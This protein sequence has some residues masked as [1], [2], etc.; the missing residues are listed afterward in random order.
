MNKRRL[1]AGIAA[2]ALC[3]QI[4]YAARGEV[5][6]RNTEENGRIARTVWEDENGQPAAGPEGYASVSYTYGTDRNT[7]EMYFDAEGQPYL[8]EGGYCGRRIQKDGKG[9]VIL[10]EY[11]DR[12]GKRVL[13]RKGYGM[14][15]V[16]YFQFGAV[17]NV[18]YYGLKK[19]VT[20]PSLGYASIVYEYSNKTMVGKTFRDE[21]GNDVDCADGYASIRQKVDKQYRVLNTRYTHADGSL[22]AGPDGWARCVRERD[23]KGRITSIR[24]YDENEQL[25]DRGTGYAWEEYT[26]DGDDI[27]KVTRY[28]ADGNPVADKAGVVTFVREEKDGRVLRERFLD[29]DGNRVTNS[30]AVAEIVYGYDEQGRLE[31]VSY[32]DT[33]GSPARC[34]KGYA[35]YRDTKDGDGATVSRVYQGPDGSPAETAGGYSEVKYL[36]DE[37]KTLTST[38]YYDLN[39][40][41]VQAE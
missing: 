7:V 37:T 11:L 19:A 22:A 27:T 35:G 29:R 9:N 21:Q 5:Q 17:R 23:K 16:S 15:T 13:N 30:L 39:G 14:V 34:N 12:N 24:Y 8:T 20:V 1:L 36:Y 10:I 25:T 31:T 2:L 40:N 28:A 3:L 32:L 38:Q 6:A 26:Y 18:F 33:D 41:P 4:P